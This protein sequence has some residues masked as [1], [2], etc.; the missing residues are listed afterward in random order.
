MGTPSQARNA[1]NRSVDNRNANRPV[2]ITL[3]GSQAH[4]LAKKVSQHESLVVVEQD[5]DVIVCYGGDG[6]LLAAELRWPGVPKVPVLNSRRGRRCIPHPAHE[7]LHGLATHQLV[8]NHYMKI[9]GEVHSGG[10]RIHPEPLVALNEFNVHMGHINSA[11]RFQL[12]LNG[13]PY[14]SGIELLGDGFVVC[15]P[16]G[17][18]AYFAQITR[19]IFTQGIGV[20]FKSTNAH[21]DHIVVPDTTECRLQIT[22]GPAVLAFDSADEYVR[23]EEGDEVL[24]RKHARGAIILTCGPV[25]R[26]D[27]PF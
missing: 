6:T 9:E 19:G 20:A 21:V 18:T 11:V 23:I 10:K 24:V 27:Q 16:F 8:S 4:T 1:D 25:K 15:T 26:L 17:S 14:D 3:F 5:P 22:R 12:W 13:D 2:H 7:V